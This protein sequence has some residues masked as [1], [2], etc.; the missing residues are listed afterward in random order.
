[1]HGRRIV[2]AVA[3]KAD[4]VPHLLDR[5]DDPLLLI[6]IHLHEQIGGLGD[7]PQ[8]FVRQSLQVG[9]REHAIGAQADK[10]GDVLCDR[11]AV[12]GDDLDGHAQRRQVAN[13]VGDIRLR[14][15]EERQE[16]RKREIPL[17]LFAVQRLGLQRS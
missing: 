1:M 12:P 11:L 9:A 14:P 13:G 16:P 15:I 7:S 4:D 6:G 17:H 5:Q 3:E 10:R 8:R 2:H